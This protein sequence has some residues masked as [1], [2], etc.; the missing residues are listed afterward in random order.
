MYAYILSTKA[1]FSCL[2]HSR[3]S[4]IL[5]LLLTCFSRMLIFANDRR[6]VC[7]GIQEKVFST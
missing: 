1:R 4:F 7:F 3:S 6:S 5:L 2:K